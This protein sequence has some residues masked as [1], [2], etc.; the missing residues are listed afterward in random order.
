MH[1]LCIVCADVT[2]G[3]DDDGDEDCFVF[4]GNGCSSRSPPTLL[5]CDFLL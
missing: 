2:M 1:N 5:T 3:N 4:D